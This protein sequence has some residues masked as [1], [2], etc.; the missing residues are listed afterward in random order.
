MRLQERTHYD[1]CRP[2]KGSGVDTGFGVCYNTHVEL[3]QGEVSEWFKELV[4]KTSDTARYRGFESHPLR[5]SNLPK[6]I[7]RQ[8]S[9]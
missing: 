8:K 7:G 5:Q 4:L 2:A 9:P 3:E 6:M 1:R